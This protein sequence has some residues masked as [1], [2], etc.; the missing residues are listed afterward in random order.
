MSACDL[1][2]FTVITLGVSL[3]Q[4]SCGRPWLVR[5]I[6]TILIINFICVQTALM[7]LSD[8]MLT[9]SGNVVLVKEVLC[10]EFIDLYIHFLL[11]SMSGYSVLNVLF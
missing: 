3:V 7:N 9:G 11:E 2:D 1:T 5:F 10:G 6:I 4:C 8:F